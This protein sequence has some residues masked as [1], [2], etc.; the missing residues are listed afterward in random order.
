MR[1]KS[2]EGSLCEEEGVYQSYCQAPSSRVPRSYPIHA[3][4]VV[5]HDAIQKR[6][7]VFLG[8]HSSLST[9]SVSSLTMGIVH[10]ELSLVLLPP[11]IVVGKPLPW[12]SL[13]M[14]VSKN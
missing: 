5:L 9:I 2:Y 1:W 12:A 8:F 14:M 13:M 6:I 11:G 7:S 3:P 10:E 4:I